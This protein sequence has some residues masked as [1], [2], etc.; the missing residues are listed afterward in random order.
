MRG[1][2]SSPHPA[3]NHHRTIVHGVF[4]FA[5]KRGRFD[6]NPVAAVKQRPEPPGRERIVSPAE[7]QTLWNKAADDREMPAFL[8]LAGTTTMRKGEILSLRWERVHLEEG[9]G[10]WHTCRHSARQACH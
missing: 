8:A 2:E 10:K 3:L 4:N 7:F 6:R 5:L 9:T 1:N